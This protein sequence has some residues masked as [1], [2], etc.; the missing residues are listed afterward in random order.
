MGESS[1]LFCR[2]SLWD[3]LG[4]LDERFSL[5][6]GG[7][8]N[9]DLYR[10][11]CELPDV[12]LVTLIG[13]GTFHQHHGGAATSRRFTWDEMHDEYVAIR[14]RAHHPPDR[15]PVYLGR[16]APNVLPHLERSARQAI[17][18]LANERRRGPG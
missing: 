1:S 13:E 18:R 8:V 5:P 7:L 2:R 14:G 17:D 3:E 12:E 6:G 10:R 9:H 15:L 16:V 4:G 11:A